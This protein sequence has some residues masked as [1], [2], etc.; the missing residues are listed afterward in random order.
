ML[1][2]GLLTTNSPSW[3]PGPKAFLCPRSLPKLRSHPRAQFH[4]DNVVNASGQPIEFDRA[5]PSSWSTVF[6]LI[7][8]Y[9]P[10]MVRGESGA[11]S[12]A[13]AASQSSPL[14]IEFARQLVSQ[15][16]Q[17]AQHIVVDLLGNP[18]ERNPMQN[19]TVGQL[20]IYGRLVHGRQYSSWR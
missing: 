3:P 2:R 12:R 16:R 6:S 5:K 20:L 8:S 15:L 10:S 11:R 19:R 4:A 9:V 18:I 13:V 17:Q 7:F 14:A 1:Q